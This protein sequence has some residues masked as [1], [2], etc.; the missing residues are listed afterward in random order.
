MKSNYVHKI[1]IEK[2]HIIILLSPSISSKV[3]QSIETFILE[4]HASAR[5]IVNIREDSSKNPIIIGVVSPKD[6]S[7]V[8]PS[9]NHK[10]LSSDDLHDEVIRIKNGSFSREKMLKKAYMIRVAKSSPFNVNVE[11][12]AEFEERLAKK[13]YA[14]DFGFVSPKMSYGKLPFI[15]GI[16]SL[17]GTKANQKSTDPRYLSK[18]TSC[19]IDIVNN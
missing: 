5:A 9:R 3:N 11:N 10:K 2:H 7:I 14:G 18:Y 13:A 16:F 17:M 1:E 19:F 12:L 6:V 4:K 8:Y 15:R